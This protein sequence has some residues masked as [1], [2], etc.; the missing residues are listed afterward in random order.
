MA[1]YLVAKEILIERHAG[2]VN[3][4]VFTVPEI[5]DMTGRTA[6]FG[7]YKQGG[8]EVILKGEEIEIDGQTITINLAPEDTA[9][10]VGAHVWE[11]E[12]LD[13]DGP[14]KIGEGDFK[15]KKK[16]IPSS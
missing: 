10:K 3:D 12:V 14:I 8:E 13:D 5:I 16:W 11:L 2:V 1:S 6:R 7:V 15:I 4:I 9:G